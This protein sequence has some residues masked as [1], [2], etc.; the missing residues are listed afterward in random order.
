[1][2]AKVLYNNNAASNFHV[3]QKQFNNYFTSSKFLVK[4]KL[5]FFLRRQPWWCQTMVM[6]RRDSY[7]K[8]EFLVLLLW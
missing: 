7:I 4:A 1:M 5:Q 3:N 8:N 6:P 2:Q